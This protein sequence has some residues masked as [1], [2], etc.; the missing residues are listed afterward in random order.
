MRLARRARERG[1][2]ALTG[3]LRG[4][5]DWISSQTQLLRFGDQSKAELVA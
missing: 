1:Q 4:P 5:P 3:R 2:A